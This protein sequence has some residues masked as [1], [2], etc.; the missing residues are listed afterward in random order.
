MKKLIV[1][2]GTCGLS[3][4]AQAV[5]DRLGE[6]VAE[7]PDQCELGITGCIGMCFR[8]PLV[9][10]NDG[11][12]RVIY[13][14][15][16]TKAAEQ[17]VLKHVLNDERIVDENLV[18]AIE[19]DASTLGDEAQYI[20][21][22]ERIVLRNCGNIDPESI[23]EY[24]ATGGYEGARKALLDLTP[25]QVIQEVKD[26][27]LRGRGGAGF[28]TG[29]KWSFCA[30][31]DGDQKYVVCNAD[32]GDPGAFM[33]RALLEGMIV[34]AKAIGA[35]FGYIYCRAEYPLAIKRLE[36]A[37]A[38]AREK[39]FLGKDIMGS[40]F[41]F[42]M[43]IKQGA[44]A[45]VCGEET[46]LFA[47]IEGQRGMP[48]IRP[49][50]PAEAGLWQKPTNN[51]NVETYANIPWIMRNG[52]AEYAKFGTEKSKGTKVFALAG[53]VAK[54]GLAEVP[55][56]TTIEDLVFKIGGG[57][58]EGGTFKAVQM[59]GPS[60]GCIPADM[61]TT[62]VDFESIPKT[63]AI[64][65]SGGMV[66]MDQT[67]CMVEIARFFLEFTQSE[68]C[69][70]CTFCRIGTLRMLEILERLVHGEGTPED[71]PKLE[72]LSVRIKEASLCGLGQTA[73]NPVQ[74]T[75]RYYL[76]E[77]EAHIRDHKCPA[78]SCQALVDFFIDGERCNGCTVCAKNC[79]VDAI[80]GIKKEIHII[81]TDL[82]VKCGK[83]LTSCSFDAI[84][85]Q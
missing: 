3:A 79:P 25:D 34:C 85:T 59:G 65:G 66:V 60:G 55:M 33:D 47:S 52:A 39:G 44:G 71:I 23:D 12:S 63:G 49:P 81:D 64:M 84:F 70:K 43:K 14:G 9:E 69:G 15:V 75:L 1:G 27:G 13:G 11:K 73:P 37:L 54:G 77:Y 40:G 53:R 6:L 26:S 62:P 20:D 42:D 56:G 45:F 4:G 22:Q 24:I 61:K 80:A 74:T 21:L 82:C 58:K 78:G 46:A 51:N 2:M 18:Y 50:F 41:D 28:P 35:T 67:T 31:Y 7:Y 36:L 30:G 48:R 83:C 16:D 32:E 17:I 68:S 72:E 10:V 8:E 38:A 5:Y 76:H 19:E 57:I 29:L